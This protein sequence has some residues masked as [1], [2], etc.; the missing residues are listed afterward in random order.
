MSCCSPESLWLVYTIHSPNYYHSNK[1]NFVVFS[2]AGLMTRTS[3]HQ[4]TVLS[5][6]D[7]IFLPVKLLVNTPALFPE[8]QSPP[9]LP[10]YCPVASI[11]KWETHC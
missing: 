7:F 9:T 3:M 8:A 11:K 4:P 6:A 1:C 5:T 2:L 10:P